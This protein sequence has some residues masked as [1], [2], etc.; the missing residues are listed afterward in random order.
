LDRRGVSDQA[1]TLFVQQYTSPEKETLEVVEQ[2]MTTRIADLTS[3]AFIDFAIYQSWAFHQLS[4]VQKL[5]IFCRN[6][7]KD[8]A[9]GT[10]MAAFSFQIIIANE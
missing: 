5:L 3:E 7:N 9:L 8:Y 10:L 2:I 1:W 6:R 4:A